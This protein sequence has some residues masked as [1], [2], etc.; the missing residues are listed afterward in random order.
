MMA[1]VRKVAQGYTIKRPFTDRAGRVITNKDGTP[2]MIDDAILPDWRAASWWLERRYPDE[3]GRTR[4]EVTGADGG[5]IRF[6]IIRSDGD[7]TD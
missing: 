5:T 1:T 6:E 3:Y 7:T 2:M 4:T